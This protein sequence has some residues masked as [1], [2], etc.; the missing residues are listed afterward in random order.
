MKAMILAAGYGTRL[1]PLTNHKPKALVEIDGIPM[2]QLIIVKLINTGVDEIIINTH[3]F[4]DQIAVFLNSNNHFGIRIELSHENE[5]LGTG[6]GLK[7]AEYFFDDNQPFFLHNVDILSTI[8]LKQMYR[9]HQE[10][11]AMVTLA[12]QSRATSRGF[13]V[14]EQNVICGHEDKDNER[15]RLK[16]TPQGKSRFMAFCGIHII[17]SDIFQFMHEIG[18]FSIIDSYLKLIEQGFPIFGFPSDDFYWKDIGKL[19]TLDEIHQELNSG[20]IA[21]QNLT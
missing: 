17:S 10:H 14:D 12:I 16:R 6:G 18:R 2:L 7:K 5:I 4:A 3:H 19:K 13:I 21:I 1:Q 8:D 15:I 11:K 20:I 9:F